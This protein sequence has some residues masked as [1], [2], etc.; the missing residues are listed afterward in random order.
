MGD[1]AN[2]PKTGCLGVPNTLDQKGAVSAGGHPNGI[3]GAGPG[4]RTSALSV[5][6]TLA[7]K[8]QQKNGLGVC[9]RGPSGDWKTAERTIWGNTSRKK[10]GF[11]HFAT[12]V[13]IENMD[14]AG[15]KKEV[16]AAEDEKQQKGGLKRGKRAPSNQ[17]SGQR[18]RHAFGH[19]LARNGVVTW[20][21]TAC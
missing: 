8:R 19:R 3:G 17:P 5:T 10:T 16:R 21:R 1:H 6:G 7:P 4:S 14:A 15:E 9:G 13:A 2:V 20:Q 11:A 18:S 12:R